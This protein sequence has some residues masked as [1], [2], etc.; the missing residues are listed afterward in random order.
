ML[1][2]KDTMLGREMFV[3]QRVFD[4]GFHESMDRLGPMQRSITDQADKLLR[5]L[6]REAR[7]L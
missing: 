3:W 4:T 2:V 5:F 6:A 1:Q 7:H